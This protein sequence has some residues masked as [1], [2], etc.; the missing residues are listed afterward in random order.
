LFVN[1][2]EALTLVRFPRMCATDWITTLALG[3]S[4]ILKREYQTN[5]Y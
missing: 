1:A 3:G 4:L 5:D 2:D